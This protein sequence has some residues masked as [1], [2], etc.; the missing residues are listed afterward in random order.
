MD[1]APADGALRLIVVSVALVTGLLL[2]AGCAQVNS[3]GSLE[4]VF[5]ADV[6][7]ML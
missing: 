1:G 6:A 4:G 5:K 3:A 2:L 7:H